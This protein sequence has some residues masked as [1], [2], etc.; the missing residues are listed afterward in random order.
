M[1]R[2][3]RNGAAGDDRAVRFALRTVPDENELADCVELLFGQA[4][5]SASHGFDDRLA[6]DL[7]C[8]IDDR[9]FRRTLDLAHAVQDRRE[10]S[11]FER[12]R[13]CLHQSTQVILAT[14]PAVQR[15]GRC[16]R[17]PSARAVGALARSFGRRVRQVHGFHAPRRQIGEQLIG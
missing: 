10:V 1:M 16:I 12:R 8:P 13:S 9:D 14:D 6:S 7:R 2:V 11:L 4:G 15:V 3:R 17:G 5:N